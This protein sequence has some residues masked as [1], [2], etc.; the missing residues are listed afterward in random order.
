MNDINLIEQALEQLEEVLDLFDEAGNNATDF[1]QASKY[2]NVGQ[3]VKMTM[4]YIK[5]ALL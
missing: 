5:D 3:H 4:D 2:A 1:K